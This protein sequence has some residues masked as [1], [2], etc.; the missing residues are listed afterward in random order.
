CADPW[1]HVY[2]EGQGSVLPC[3]FW[4]SHEGELNEGQ[5]LDDIWNSSFYR[6][7]RTG[8]AGNKPLPACAT[9]VKYRGSNVDDIHCH[10]TTRPEQGEKLIAEIERRGL[11]PASPQEVVPR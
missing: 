11:L 9:C 10:I 4:G 3:C 8:M 2:V 6:E 7:L 5:E 1:Q